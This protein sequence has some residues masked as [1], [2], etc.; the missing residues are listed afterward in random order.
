MAKNGFSAKLYNVV[1]WYT[2]CIYSALLKSR[3][4]TFLASISTNALYLVRAI[5]VKR[6]RASVLVLAQVHVVVYYV[7]AEKKEEM[8]NKHEKRYNM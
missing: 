5:R 4:P 7:K 3:L 1:F 2:S 8:Q 6:C